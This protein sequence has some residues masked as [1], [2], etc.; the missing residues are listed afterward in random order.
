MK[1]TPQLQR[2]LE[3]CPPLPYPVE[4]TG[5]PAAGYRVRMGG[6]TNPDTFTSPA[7][8]LACALWCLRER[9]SKETPQ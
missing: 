5:T 8:A 2:K 6:V 1:L 3:H 9:P 4:I 7:A